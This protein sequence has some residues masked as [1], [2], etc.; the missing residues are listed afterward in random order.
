MRCDDQSR[1]EK[2]RER[3]KKKDLKMEEG[4]KIQGIK[5][6]SRSWKGRK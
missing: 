1:G 6:T 3:E 2:E 4:T 5:V